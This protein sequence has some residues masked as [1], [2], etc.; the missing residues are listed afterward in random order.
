M[1][2]S[3]LRPAMTSLAGVFLMAGLI[4]CRGEPT[5]PQA[6]SATPT[7]TPMLAP[8]LT[9]TPALTTAAT[10]V[11]PTAIT[12]EESHEFETEDFLETHGVEPYLSGNLVFIA[13][14]DEVVRSRF[15]L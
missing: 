5:T 3:R 10:P 4:P 9:L 12:S 7:A 8:A 6:L 2:K 14:W 13:R 11:E 1:S 15:I